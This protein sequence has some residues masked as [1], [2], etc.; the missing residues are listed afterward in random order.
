MSSEAYVDANPVVRE[1]YERLGC[2]LEEGDDAFV[3]RGPALL[4]AAI[5]DPAFFDGVATDPAPPGS[6]TR[7][8]VVGDPGRHVVRFME[9]PPG[10]SLLPHEHHGRPCFEVLVEGLLAVVDMRADP[11]SDGLYELTPLGTTVARP[12]DAAVVDPRV[13][14]VHAVYSPVRSRSLHVYPSDEAHAYGYCLVE[15]GS[16]RYSRERFDLRREPRE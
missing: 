11:V 5:R 14:G 13:N 4:Q 2:L 15:D 1:C 6:Y 9:W 16:D 3:G 12:G 8:R 10:F 7:R